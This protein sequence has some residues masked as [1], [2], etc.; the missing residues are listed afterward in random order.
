MGPHNTTYAVSYRNVKY[1]RLEMKTGKLLL[2]LPP[3]YAADEL[4]KK[5]RDWLKKKR[6]FIEGCLR[7]SSRIKIVPRRDEAFKM[8]LDVGIGVF[9]RDLGVKVRKVFLRRMRTKW[10]SLSPRRNLTIN[11]LMKYLPSD[12]VEYVLFHELA[13]NIEKRHNERFW[14]IIRKVFPDYRKLEKALFAYWFLIHRESD[15]HRSRTGRAHL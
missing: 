2:V 4:L 11:T 5:H 3:G 9:S 14:G 6:E 15:S 7:E 12:L 1:P 8:V 10:A 13:H